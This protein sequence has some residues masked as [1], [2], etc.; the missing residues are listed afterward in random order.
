MKFNKIPTLALLI[1][2]L[3]APSF[4]ISASQRIYSLELEYDEGLL[5]FLDVNLIT[6]FPD[7]VITDKIDFPPDSIIY[8]LELLSSDDEILYQ[9]YFGIP[10]KI[11][12]IEDGSPP[13]M[14]EL[15]Q[16]AFTLLFPYY[17]N[18]QTISITKDEKEI[19][20]VDVSGFQ[21]YCGDRKCQFDENHQNCPQ[22]CVEFAGTPPPQ[23]P[24]TPSVKGKGL[25]KYLLYG[26]ITVVLIILIIFFI[27]KRTKKKPPFGKI[28]GSF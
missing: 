28:E 9:T 21:M 26:I 24:V 27:K 6:G 13:S 18:G 19:L 17:K 3:V 8:K 23:P 22:D 12:G 10:N 15:D 4:I 14:M 7:P 11:Y 20:T 2:F 5:K 16:V 1:I 25:T